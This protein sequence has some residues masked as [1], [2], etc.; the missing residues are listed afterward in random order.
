MYNHCRQLTDYDCAAGA[1]AFFIQIQSGREIGVERIARKLG[2]HPETGTN[3]ETIAEYLSFLFRYE[4]YKIEHGHYLQLQKVEFPLLV[5]YW[6]GQD[7]HYGVITG[8]NLGVGYSTVTLFDPSD[9]QIHEKDWSDFTENWYS[10]RYGKN[11]GLYIPSR[12]AS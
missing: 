4:G 7:G 3:H 5:N 1:L 2:C 9:G 6:S 12:K 10:K 8:L 11:W